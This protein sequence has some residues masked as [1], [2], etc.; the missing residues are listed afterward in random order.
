MGFALF[1]YDLAMSGLVEPV[2]HHPIVAGDGTE[3]PRDL[4]A[5]LRQGRR[6]QDGLE[7]ALYVTREIDDLTRMFEFDDQAATARAVQE[8]IELDARIAHPAANADRQDI[9]RLV[10]MRRDAGRKIAWQGRDRFSQQGSA[11]TEKARGIVAVLDD[12]P[13][14]SLESGSNAPLGW[15]DPARCICSSSQLERSACPKAGRHCEPSD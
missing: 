1:G 13:R 6:G 2:D 8:N 12:D 14:R 7:G 4:I 5:Q 10:Q 15:I 11:Q 9:Q 3:D